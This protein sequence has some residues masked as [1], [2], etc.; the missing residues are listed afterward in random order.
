M[1]RCH[2]DSRSFA[3]TMRGA[4]R[5]ATQRLYLTVLF[6]RRPGRGAS[7]NEVRPSQADT[8]A[9][10]WVQAQSV[11]GPGDKPIRLLTS[12]VIPDD[13]VIDLSCK[14]RRDV[15]MDLL[16]TDRVNRVRTVSPIKVKR[17][18]DVVGSQEFPSRGACA[19]VDPE[20]PTHPSLVR[21]AQGMG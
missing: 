12:W 3:L 11:K 18:L 20:A 5:T 17:L 13:Q 7:L 2:T 15:T 14:G 10:V 16:H 9:L 1:T 6:P 19:I 21:F 4:V 8:R